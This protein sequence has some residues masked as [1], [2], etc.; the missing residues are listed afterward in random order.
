[1]DLLHETTSLGKV[2]KISLL[3]LVRGFAP[4]RHRKYIHFFH[5]QYPFGILFLLL[6]NDI[7]CL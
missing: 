6:I 7:D 1:M 2:N 5:N 4:H 3:S